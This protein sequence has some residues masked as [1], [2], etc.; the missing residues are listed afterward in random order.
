MNK[1]ALLEKLVTL[2]EEKK[3]ITKEIWRI[4]EE[5]NI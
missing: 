5:L 1:I 4:E 2:K 3:A